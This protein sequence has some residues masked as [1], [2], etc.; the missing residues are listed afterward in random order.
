M[1]GRDAPGTTRP[2]E[3]RR[4]CDYLPGGHASFA[5]AT[6]PGGVRC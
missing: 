5:A 1:T 6:A 3:R 4:V 2:A